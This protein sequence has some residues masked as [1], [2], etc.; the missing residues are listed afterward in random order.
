MIT[1]ISWLSRALLSS[2]SLRSGWKLNFT[3]LF[4]QSWNLF[5]KLSHFLFPILHFYSKGNIFSCLNMYIQ[6]IN[7]S[8]YSLW[9]KSTQMLVSLSLGESIDRQDTQ[10]KIRDMPWQTSARLLCSNWGLTCGWPS[11]NQMSYLTLLT[12]GGRRPGT[13]TIL[14]ISTLA[15]LLHIVFRWKKAEYPVFVVFFFFW[16][17]WIS[18][19]AAF[20]ASFLS[21][22]WGGAS[23][24]NLTKLSHLLQTLL[25]SSSTDTKLL[26]W[27]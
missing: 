6:Y 12:I 20:P 9:S 13:N 11:I 19:I 2:T 24:T 15:V 23:S 8:L 10:A 17:S 21:W 7:P 25:R 4:V 1:T 3:K 5:G 22:I 26:R 14:E 16:I 18:Q 27:L